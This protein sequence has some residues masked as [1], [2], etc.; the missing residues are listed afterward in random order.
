[1]VLTLTDCDNEDMYEKQTY[2][3][4]IFSGSIAPAGKY[5]NFDNFNYDL[6]DEYFL[7]N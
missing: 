4:N 7:K 2:N 6:E 1:M 3:T 5:S